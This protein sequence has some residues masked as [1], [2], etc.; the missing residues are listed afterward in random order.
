MVLETKTKLTVKVNPP[1]PIYIGDGLLEHFA[2]QVKEHRIAIV[3]DNNV[4]ALYAPK[5]IESLKRQA[6]EGQLY[7]VP[8][9]EESKSA[10][11]FSYLLE[12]LAED[13]FDRKSAIIALGGGVV[14]D[15]AGFSAASFMRGIKFYQIPTS[16]LAMV[17]ASVGGKTGINLPQGKN[18]V[19]AFWQPQAVLIDVSLLASLPDKEFKQGAV[20]LYKHGLLR[21][22]SILTDVPSE[23][24][25]KNAD[26]QFLSDL[27]ARSVKVK[28]D[29]VA[30]D[31]KEAGERAYLNL[32]HTLAHALEAASDH[33]LGHGD[34]VAYG[35]LFNAYLAK[36]L[37][38]QDLS[39]DIKAF[40]SWV[41]PAPLPC[42]SYEE[43]E[44]YL[45]RDKKNTNGK[46]S[47]VVLEEL[48][49]PTI[50]TDI[51][52]KHLKNAW[53]QLLESQ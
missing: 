51:A 45:K 32:G 3:T 53:Q 8:A 52:P 49:K 44:P 39:Q 20:E 16:L 10:T 24:F 38:Y 48:N 37:G 11:T 41:K 50:L 31:E 26:P 17:D 23:Q 14:G 30:Q 22:S 28:A 18:L 1:Y 7:E 4:A 27:I 36:S 35:L 2:E 43:L 25:H 15:L 21:D 6:K 33:K 13:G 42:N 19:G 47:F 40:F 9:G 29:I 46:I 34:A 5:L 12:Q